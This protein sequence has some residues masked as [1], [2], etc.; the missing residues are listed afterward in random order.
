MGANQTGWFKSIEA[1]R[2]DMLPDEFRKKYAEVLNQKRGGGYWIWKYALLEET[3]KEIDEGEFV[4][5]LDAGCQ[6]NPN[7]TEK[8]NEYIRAI[9]SSPYDMLCLPLKNELEYKWTT[10]YAFQL[11]GV[12]KNSTEIRETNQFWAGALV[13]QKGNH[14]RKWIQSILE[15]LDKDPLVIT[16]RDQ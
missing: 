8:F 3:M 2:P 5:Y 12:D 16:D 7:A 14:Y 6:I 11:M 15:V 1:W 9:Q 10:E 4:V 13:M